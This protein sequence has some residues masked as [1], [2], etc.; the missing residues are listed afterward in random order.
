M[1]SKNP[2]T[3]DMLKNEIEI[4][5]IGHRSRIMNK[6][7]EDSKEFLKKMKKKGLFIISGKEAK[8]CDCII[9]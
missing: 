7:I 3:D 9:F 6:L 2:L 8:S 5:K 1:L 4:N